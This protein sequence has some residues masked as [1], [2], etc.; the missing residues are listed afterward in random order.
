VPNLRSLLAGIAALLALTPAR[1][2]AAQEKSLSRDAPSFYLYASPA[3]V[4]IPVGEDVVT[5]TVDVSYEWGI[6]FGG[7]FALG[8]S[9]RFGL[10]VGFGF[11]HNPATLDPAISDLCD[12]FGSSCHIHAF[13]LLPELRLGGIPSEQLYIYA[14][15]SPGLGLI[16]TVVE[17]AFVSSEDTD[18]G[19]NLG[20]GGGLQ[21]VVWKGLFVG[22]EIGADLGFYTNDEADFGNDDFNAYLVDV[23]GLVGY[24]F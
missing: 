10:G 9:K 6:G 1:F 8:D 24:Y 5:D 19:F 4:A 16:H 21:Y 14:Q 15:V 23:K 12:A 7:L 22:G 20:V 3:F 18:P 17:N 13:R 11:E 2:A